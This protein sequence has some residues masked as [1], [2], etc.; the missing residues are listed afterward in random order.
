MLC[1]TALKAEINFT[2]HDLTSPVTIFYGLNESHSK[3]W[4][5]ITNDGLIGISYFKRSAGERYTG[6]LIYKSIQPDGT[7]KD[8]I[9]STGNSLE[10]S[11]LVFD[12]QS[13][14][15]IFVA[16]SDEVDQ[17]IV[18]FFKSSDIAWSSE[19]I[20]HFNNEGGKYIYEMSAERGPD[21]L[22]HLLVLKTRSNPDS[23]DYYYAYKNA[24]LYHLNND[25]NGNW[26][27]ELIYNYDTVWTLDEYSKAL[28]RQDMKVDK[29]G[30][31]HVVF[32]K[33]INSS[34]RL[35][36]ATNKNGCWEIET[37]VNFSAGTRDDGGWFPS[38]A[39]DNEDQPYVSCVYVGRCSSGSATYA[40][41]LFVSRDENSW[42]Q[43]IIAANDDGYYGSD[44]RN[45]TGALSHLV[46]DKNNQPH[47]VFSDIASSHSA[48]NYWNLGNIRYA[49]KENDNWMISTIYEQPLPNGFFNAVEMYG[50]CLLISDNVDKIRVSDSSLLLTA[51]L[52]ILSLWFK[53]IL[54]TA[55]LQKS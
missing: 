40:K 35:E 45:Y 39:L 8:E 9:V 28:N 10:V 54:R 48:M 31:I 44:G 20:V 7:E 23:E 46:F 6:D 12:S 27:K 22:F 29:N 2:Q 41:L 19:N 33:Q 43:E 51:A 52:I 42:T 11:V 3:S 4:A 18:H 32:N 30:K 53:K 47:I 36:Y 16:S 38:L 15:H 50:M 34:S 5:Q 55:V 25:Q 1:L 26:Q 49:V 37:A 14:P 24:H 21:N 13:K 17:T